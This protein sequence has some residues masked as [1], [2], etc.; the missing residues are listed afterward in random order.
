M[1]GASKRELRR[2]GLQVGGAFLVFGSVSW[3]RNHLYPPM[4]LWTLGA[5]L[6]FPAL[7]APGL[8]VPA[9]RFWFGPVM[10]VAARIGEV[11]SRVI[12]GLMFYLVFTPVGFVL[13]RFRDP[14]DRALDD[15]R[16]S[17]WHPRERGP[18]DPARY[19]QQF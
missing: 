9:H 1:A 7:V 6:F 5:L 19:E 2:F 11:V 13:R 4:V 8:L 14:L 10:R 15:G 18:V 12:L 16:A 17:D 3:W